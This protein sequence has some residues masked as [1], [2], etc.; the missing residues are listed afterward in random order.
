MKLVYAR[1][2]NGNFGDDLN[3]WLWQRAL[4]GY[5]NADPG[6]YFFG[7]GTI[8]REKYV[9][10]IPAAARKVVFG[11]GAGYGAAPKVDR[12]WTIYCVRGPLTARVLGIDASLAITDPAILAVDYLKDLNVQRECCGFIPHHKTAE[13]SNWRAVCEAAGLRYINPEQKPEEVMRQIAG[14]RSVIAESMHGAILAD[15]FR[16][17][18]MPVVLSRGILPFK[19]CD[20]SAS[21]GINYRPAVIRPFLYEP[22][23]FPQGK[24]LERIGKRIGARLGMSKY[25]KRYADEVDTGLHER[26]AV[27]SALRRLQQSMRFQLSDDHR[28]VEVLERLRNEL[29][30]VSADWMAA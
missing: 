14:C 8:L 27:A 26:D 7:I 11:S 30:S 28:F 17:P 2:K 24:Q 10:E 29:K 9:R 13:N 25:R 15:A 20:W 19:W 6:S 3:P 1:I 12:S 16:V 23:R 22:N 18:W 5:L 4:P 21:L